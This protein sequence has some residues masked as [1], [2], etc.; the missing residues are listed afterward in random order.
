MT[1]RAQ[2]FAALAQVHLYGDQPRFT[3]DR[4]NGCRAK[5]LAKRRT[6]GGEPLDCVCKHQQIT[7]SW[8]S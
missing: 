4:N 6:S 5:P 8:T 7:S 1:R 2:C 3:K